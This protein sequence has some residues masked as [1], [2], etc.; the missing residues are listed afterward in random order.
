MRHTLFALALGALT[1]SGC[2]KKLTEPE[3]KAPMLRIVNSTFQTTDA[4]STVSTAEPR[5]IDVLIDS[6]L[7]TPGV[8]ALAPNS[9]S[10]SE[11]GTGYRPFPG[12]GLHTFVARLAAPATPNTSLYSNNANPRGEFLPRMYFTPNTHY[13]IIV[14]GVAPTEGRPATDMF[15]VASTFAM[16]DDLS[17]PPTV[18]GTLLSRFRLVNAAPFGGGASTSGQSVQAFITEGATPPTAAELG[19]LAPAGGTVSYRRQS[20][21]VDVKPGQYVITVTTTAAARPVLAQRVVNLGAGEVRTFLLQNTAYAAT[22]STAN[23]QLTELVD[24]GHQ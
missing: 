11:D 14:S 2:S 6:S 17:R 4:A 19:L 15:Y 3:P 22:A 13:T 21:Y 8:A 7:A 16:V 18:N 5:A 1:V 9:V 12:H 10:G 23:H 24:I 20:T